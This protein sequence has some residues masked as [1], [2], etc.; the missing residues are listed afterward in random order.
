MNREIITDLEK[1][2][3]AAEPIDLQ[4]DNEESKAK[5]QSIKQDLIDTLEANPS[6]L[7][8]SAPQIGL[9]ARVIAVRFSDAIKLFINPIIT[10]KINYSLGGEQCAS[11]PGKEILL[12]RPEELQ[13]VYYNND[14]KYEDNKLLGAAARVFDQQYQILDGVTPDELGLVSD[15]EEDGPLSS[16]SEDEFQQIAEVYKQFIA[17]KA[18]TM[19]EAVQAD[20]D[21][22]PKLKEMKFAEQ[23]IAGKAAIVEDNSERIKANRRRTQARMLINKSLADSEKLQK[24]QQLNKFLKKIGK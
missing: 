22:A 18:K 20:E 13:L 24:A 5:I 2:K 14:N 3:E 21:L 11:M 17:T 8:L 9:N 16:L 4:L 6:L 23:V 19:N 1:L 10:K 15:I 7:A 12:A